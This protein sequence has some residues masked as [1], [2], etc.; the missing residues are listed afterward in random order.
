VS[1][2][3]FPQSSQRTGAM[4]T[5]HKEPA[6]PPT[7][8]ECRFSCALA[9]QWDQLAVRRTVR[10]VDG[11][12]ARPAALH[13]LE[14]QPALADVGLG[15]DSDAA[16]ASFEETVERR[17]QHRQLVGAADESR[18][19]ADSRTV[20]PAAQRADTDELVDD[21]GH[22]DTLDI[23]GAEIAQL[24]V[25][26]DQARRVL[27]EVGAV[28]GGAL[29]NAL[30]QPHGVPLRRV[31]HAQV[32]ADPAD[33]DLAGV[34]ADASRWLRGSSHRRWRLSVTQLPETS[35]VYPSD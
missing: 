18:E 3:R 32:V 12:V 7:P 19:P 14:A 10:L 24:E 4:E 33:D 2:S 1:P 17:L 5:R 26:L 23:E 6:A 11:D 20:E 34:E 25:P 35:E 22:A 27:R 15:D 8:R 21:H 28:R 16:A 29:L 9:S 30:R 13:E 31:I